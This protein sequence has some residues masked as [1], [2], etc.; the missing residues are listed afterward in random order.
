MTTTTTTGREGGREEAGTEG[1][2]CL[3]VCGGL[4]QLCQDTGAWVRV[5]HDQEM[6][7]GATER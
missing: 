7:P 6:P 1:G 4:K 5:A 3:C 2:L